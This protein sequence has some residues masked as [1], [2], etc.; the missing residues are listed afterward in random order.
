MVAPV[1]V[2][3]RSEIRIP[4]AAAAT[5]R[6]AAQIVTAR[7]L[8]KIRMA[9][10][11][12]KTTSAEIRSDPTRFMAMTMTTAVT[13]AIRRLYAPALVPV[14]REKSSSKVT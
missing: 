2:T 10:S 6:T 9:E 1:G 11:A 7:K 5:E 3:A 13:T 4:T 8:L 12:G 14:A